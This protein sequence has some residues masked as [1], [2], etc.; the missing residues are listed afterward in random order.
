[1]KNFK[2][3]KSV[4]SQIPKEVNVNKFGEHKFK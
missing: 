4:N 1:M 2:N 3:D